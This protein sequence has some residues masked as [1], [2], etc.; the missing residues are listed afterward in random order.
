MS[1]TI[2]FPISERALAF[3]ANVTALLAGQI[4][5]LPVTTAGITSGQGGQAGGSAA[6]TLNQ[7]QAG[8]GHGQASVPRSLHF[9]T[10][11]QGGT[12]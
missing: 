6:T 3:Q 4:M 11:T 9:G 8:T 1:G 10:Q 5:T 12:V 7:G 2:F